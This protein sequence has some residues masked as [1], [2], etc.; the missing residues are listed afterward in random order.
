MM[1]EPLKSP[2]CQYGD[3]TSQFGSLSK[4]KMM[5]LQ[6]L[7]SSPNSTNTNTLSAFEL[8]KPVRIYKLYYNL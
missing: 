1:R 4:L 2:S 5:A 7:P 8:Q 3:E 6:C